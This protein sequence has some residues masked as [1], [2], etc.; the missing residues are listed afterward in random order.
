MD[1]REFLAAMVAAPLVKG[2]VEEASEPL[3]EYMKTWAKQ[4]FDE[5]IACHAPRFLLDVPFKPHVVEK[6]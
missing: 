2:E 3:P 5:A 4:Q 6:S 1:R